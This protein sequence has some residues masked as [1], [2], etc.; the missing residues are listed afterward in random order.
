[1][2]DH[3]A[4][5]PRTNWSAPPP[6]TSDGPLD[7]YIARIE[8]G[9]GR[10]QDCVVGEPHVH[11]ERRFPLLH[12]GLTV[13]WSVAE[14]AY[15]EYAEK[16]PGSASLQSLERIAQRGGFSPEEMDDLLRQALPSWVESVRDRTGKRPQ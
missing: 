5:A 16:F 15:V 10:C 1:M 3:R 9:Q 8:N 14:M 6:R 4:T 7:A 11:P 13:P 12:G 2:S